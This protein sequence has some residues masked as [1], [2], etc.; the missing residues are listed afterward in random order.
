MVMDLSFLK[1]ME[2]R[3]AVVTHV[4]AAGD[5]FAQ[6]GS[7]EQIY[8]PRSL[9]V[10]FPVNVGDIVTVK[11]VHNHPNH[12]ARCPWK[13]YHVGVKSQTDLS[14]FGSPADDRGS[15]VEEVVNLLDTFEMLSTAEIA[16]RLRLD[17]MVVRRQLDRMHKDGQIVR[18]DVYLSG[19]Q[20]KASRT[21]WAS[22]DV[23]YPVT[24]D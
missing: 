5:A 11:L 2:P 4:T 6:D 1:S 13:A 3:D 8:I 21:V 22:D 10:R 24:E 15:L 18:A 7:S 20:E 9:T 12:A 14:S 17:T 19:T 16:T 23:F